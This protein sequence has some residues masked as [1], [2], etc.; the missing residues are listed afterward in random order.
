MLQ[1][2]DSKVKT[3]HLI[4]HYH[5]ERRRCCAL[6]HVAAYMETA[7]IGAPVNHGVNEP[8][9]VVKREVD[10]CVFGEERVKGH[11]VHSMRMIVRHHQNAQIHHIANPTL[12]PGTYFCRSHEAAHISMVGT[13]PAQAST[14]SGS[15]PPSLV[16]NFQIDAPREQCSRASSMFNH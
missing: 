2:V 5:V 8:A 3:T 6:I 16:A 14:T 10:R 11:V 12:I 15:L 1:C 9:I 13:S 7:F 4:Q